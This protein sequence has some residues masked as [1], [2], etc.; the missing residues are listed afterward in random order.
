MGSRFCDVRAC[1]TVAEISGALPCGD[2]CVRPLDVWPPAS[3]HPPVPAQ[4][5]ISPIILNQIEEYRRQRM[6]GLLRFC[7]GM[8][9]AVGVGLLLVA[10]LLVPLP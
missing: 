3:A 5:E 8:M 10:W 2:H 9:I 6:A 4:H 1:R 7:C